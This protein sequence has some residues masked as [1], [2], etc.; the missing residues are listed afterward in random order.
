MVLILD[1]CSEL[2]AQIWSKQ[3]FLFV[4]GICLQRESRR[5]RKLPIL[6]HMCATC[7][8]L[9]SYIITMVLTIDIYLW[10]KLSKEEIAL[11]PR[12]E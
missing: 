6:H 9:P 11:T 10:F 8:E 1:G 2:S 5:I 4:A 7:C 12:Q 3:V